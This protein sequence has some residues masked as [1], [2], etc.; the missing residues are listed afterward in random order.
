[1]E[2][3][4]GSAQTAAYYRRWK[5]AYRAALSRAERLGLTMEQLNEKV[6]RGLI[7]IGAAGGLLD[8]TGKSIRKGWAGLGK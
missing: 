6:S 8:A 5:T 7:K 3:I 1:M 2:N 4:K